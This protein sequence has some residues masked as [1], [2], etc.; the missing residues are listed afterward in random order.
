MRT[1][2]CPKCNTTSQ[3]DEPYKRKPLRRVCPDCKVKNKV[4]IAQCVVC[5]KSVEC[6]G[7]KPARSSLAAVKNNSVK[8]SEE[9]SKIRERQGQLKA[10]EWLSKHNKKFASGRMKKNNPMHKKEN[11]E[12]MKTTKRVNGT[13]NVWH[14]TRG[15]NGQ[16]TPQQEKIAIAL[17]WETELP[18]PTSDHLVI[19]K[20]TAWCRKKNI[21]TNYKVDVGNR[22]LKI[23]I[24]I[25]GKGTHVGQ[26]KKL[27]KRKESLLKWKGWKVLRF[28]NEQ[29]DKDLEA[30]V[31]MV[32]S[33]I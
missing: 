4:I 24:E 32:M 20:R 5:G 28:T 6:Q 13:L 25:D 27:D 11:I 26:R 10:G 17:G 31:K 16:L 19:G 8:C 23:A 15:G 18:I 1:V 29:V 30:C 7:S 12:K 9:C 33:T 2:I 3:V 14:G 21:P 22:E